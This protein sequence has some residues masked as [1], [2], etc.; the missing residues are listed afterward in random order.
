MIK[1]IKNIKKSL[2]AKFRWYTLKINPKIYRP[3]SS[4]FISGDTFRSESSFI[5][6]E[7]QTFNP[8]SVKNN[9]VVFL[10]TDLKDIY[11]KTQHPRI[12]NKYI[13]I[14]HNSDHIIGRREEDLIDD[15]IVHWFAQN[16]SF[17]SNEKF[18]PLPIGFENRRYLHNGVVRNLKKV[19]A[20]KYKKNN[21]ILSSY[22]SATNPEVRHSLDKIVNDLKFINTQKF[23]NNFEY[24]MGLKKHSFVLCPE[25]NGLDTHRIWE[26]LLTKTMPILK[27]TDFSINFHN[28]G[29]PILLIDDWVEL[30]EI[31][32]VEVNFFYE[33]FKDFEYLKYVKKEFWMNFINEKKN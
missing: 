15:K 1:N 22:N 11:F 24:L 21:R 33:K 26:G 32:D 19:E 4:P 28:L 7:T 18:S 12:N 31:D 27:K 30:K 2:G 5:F 17:K 23:D 9:D 3:S 14:S 29:I 25:G 8:S 6:D 16:L 20:T 10:K 13:L